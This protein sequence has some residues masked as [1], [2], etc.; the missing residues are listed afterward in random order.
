MQLA[1]TSMAI[2]QLKSDKFGR[3]AIIYCQRGFLNSRWR[4]MP[5]LSSSSSVSENRRGIIL[6]QT[7]GIHNNKNC[8]FF[9][10]SK[11]SDGKDSNINKYYMSI[12]KSVNGSS[13]IMLDL[14]DFARLLKSDRTAQVEPGHERPYV[15]FSFWAIKVLS[16]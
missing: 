15:V 10:N 4:E 9:V 12:H 3:Y 6:Q 7:G 11:T 16:V 13:F 1:I 14:P 5:R 8:V 2:R